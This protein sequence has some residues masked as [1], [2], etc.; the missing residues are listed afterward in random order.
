ML[1]RWWVFCEFSKTCSIIHSNIKCNFKN[2][3]SKQQT[4]GTSWETIKMQTDCNFT[5]IRRKKNQS[6][7]A[8][9][10]SLFTYPH[11][12]ICVC[13]CV[14]FNFLIYCCWQLFSLLSSLYSIIWLQ[15]FLHTKRCS[16]CQNAK[17]GCM[18]TDNFA[19]A[20]TK[21]ENKKAT[22]KSNRTNT[23]L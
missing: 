3:K 20:M 7:V 16:F 13:V 5:T 2:A 6:K 12:Y 11:I 19:H 21:N 1:F 14:C 22:L 4:H 17:T 23:Q 15:S 18:L 8:T 10:F 9:D